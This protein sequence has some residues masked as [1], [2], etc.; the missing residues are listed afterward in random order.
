MSTKPIAWT[1]C[2]SPR[3]GSLRPETALLRNESRSSARPVVQR[4][5]APGSDPGHG[6][7]LRPAG[8][9]SFQPDT[10]VSHTSPGAD[11]AARGRQSRFEPLRGQRD[12]ESAAAARSRR[13]NAD[14][15]AEDLISAVSPS[16]DY[17]AF[18]RSMMRLAHEIAQNN[19]AVVNFAVMLPEQVLANREDL[20]YFN[21]VRFLCLTCPPAEL[22]RRIAGRA[23]PGFVT[24]VVQKWIDFNDALVADAGATDGQ[25]RSGCRSHGRTGRG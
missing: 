23:G 14:I 7:G 2:R 18:W 5:V 9:R 13:L 8:T 24:E 12:R 11:S 10:V 15:H 22:H 6:V 17:P 19:L 3:L 20:R 4:C 25:G 1:C 16:H 21:A